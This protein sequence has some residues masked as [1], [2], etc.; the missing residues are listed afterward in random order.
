MVMEGLVGLIIVGIGGFFLYRKLSGYVGIA[1]LERQ[2]KQQEEEEIERINAQL[3]A[4]RD[5][6]PALP[7]PSPGSISAGY[8]HIDDAVY[9]WI[10]LTEA[11][12]QAL[13]AAKLLDVTV[14][15]LADQKTIERRVTEYGY[16]MDETTDRINARLPQ[17]VKG[18]P[19][20]APWEKRRRLE[21]Y[22]TELSEQNRVT[23]RH[24]L[25]NPFRRA[26]KDQVEAAAYIEKLTTTV[27]PK[28]KSLIQAKPLT[29]TL[30]L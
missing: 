6:R 25:A 15:E 20:D 28:I 9:V 23:L 30:E 16:I 3:R 11:D 1:G 7:P 14:D 27:L 29:G 21:E 13:T 4:A 17:G 12:K 8:K 19:R 10:E 18:L 22:R 2:L 26:V 24:M 5:A